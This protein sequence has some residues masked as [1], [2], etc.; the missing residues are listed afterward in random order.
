MDCEINLSRFKDICDNI[1][2]IED[3]YIDKS[4]RLHYKCNP[5]TKNVMS[6]IKYLNNTK[7]KNFKFNQYSI[8]K[9]ENNYIIILNYVAPSVFSK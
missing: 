4:L 6:I 3:N 9:N 7:W 5:E 8:K 2:K 1:I